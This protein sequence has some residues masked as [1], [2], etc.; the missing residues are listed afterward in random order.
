LQFYATT[1][2][3]YNATTNPDG[4]RYFDESDVINISND[5]FIRDGEWQIAIMDLSAITKRFTAD[6]DG[7]FRATWIRFDVFNG[8]QGTT[9]EFVDVAY[10]AVCDDLKTAITY[11]K[12]VRTAL[13]RL[14]AAITNRYSTETGEIAENDQ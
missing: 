7:K 12:S 1:F 2:D 5:R 4:K 13:V 9:A 3:L 11:D 10:I 6:D 8:K 14:D